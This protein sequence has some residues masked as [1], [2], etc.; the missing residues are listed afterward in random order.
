MHNNKDKEIEKLIPTVSE[1]YT[2]I[3]VPNKLLMVICM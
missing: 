3:K 1:K 2:I